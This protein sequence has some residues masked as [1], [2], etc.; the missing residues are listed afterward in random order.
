MT[1]P[2]RRERLRRQASVVNCSLT[3]AGNRNCRTGVLARP[4][5]AVEQRPPIVRSNRQLAAERR[6]L[7]PAHGGHRVLLESHVLL[8]YSAA[9]SKSFFESLM[10]LVLSGSRCF[11]RQVFFRVPVRRLWFVDL[12][13]T[14]RSCALLRTASSDRLTAARSPVS[15]FSQLLRLR[16]ASWSAVQ[17]FPTR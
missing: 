16:A 15:E 12:S 11:Y 4:A 14:S 6:R 5:G 1:G 2:G 8:A 13:D 17:A 7:L 3:S 10:A 9:G